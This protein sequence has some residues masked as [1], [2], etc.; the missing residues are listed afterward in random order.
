MTYE[1][2]GTHPESLASGRPLVFGD[3]VQSADLTDDDARVKSLLVEV[4]TSA[5]AAPSPASAAPSTTDPK[6]S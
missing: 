1:F 4:P 6:A 5:P 3:Q 2:V